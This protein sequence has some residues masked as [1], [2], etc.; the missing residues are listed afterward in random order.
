[1]KRWAL[2]LIHVL[3]W[4]LLLSNGVRD[5]AH[6]HDAYTEKAIQA[7]GLSRGW[8][9]FFFYLAYTASFLVAFYG[10]YFFVA[11]LL[12]I[13]KKYLAAFIRLLLV[14][15]AMVLMRW[16]AE[17]KL[18]LPWLKFDNYFGRPFELIPYAKNCIGYTY[19]YA[20]FGLL[21]YFLTAAAKLE[22]EKKE[23]E[24]ER[25]QAE[26]SFLRSQ[27]PRG[28]EHRARSCG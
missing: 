6:I 15:A 14:L 7:S 9:G 28:R 26:L 20:L 19:R 11:P 27:F 2:P 13:R 8:Y 25:I 16:L 24:K 5:F 4:S 3:V 18:L 23:I 10:A 12:F 1:M 22:K 21:V 17:Y